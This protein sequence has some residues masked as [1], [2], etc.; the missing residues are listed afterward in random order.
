MQEIFKV[1]KSTFLYIN[2][3]IALF[4]VL[5]VSQAKEKAFTVV[6]DAGKYDLLGKEMFD[7]KVKGYEIKVLLMEGDKIGE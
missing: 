5:P 1:A 6:I 3:V 2:L 7:G 4:F